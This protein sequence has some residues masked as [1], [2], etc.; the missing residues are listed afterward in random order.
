[1]RDILTIAR[2]ELRSYFTDVVILIQIFILPFIIVFG[3]CS[4]FSM[5]GITSKGKEE[6]VKAYYVRA[7]ESFEEA[8]IQLGMEK[9][10]SD[11]DASIVKYKKMVEDKTLDLLLVFPEDFKI[12]EPGSRDLSNINIY[13]NSSKSESFTLYQILSEIFDEL[14]PHTFTVNSIYE[15]D[16]YNLFD[17]DNEFR[18]MLGGVI[19]T[20]VFMAVFMICMNLASNSIAGDKEH[21]FLN[22]LLVTP[23][24]RRDLAAGKSVTILV[25]SA[26]SSISAFIGMAISLPK[27]AR[28]FELSGNSY[29]IGTYV[30]LFLCVVT[31]LFVL[32]AILLIVST[33]SKDVKQA[34]T[35]APASI[36]LIMIPSLLSSTE[37]FGRL[38]DSFGAKNYYIPVWNSV[39]LMQDI[40]S[41]DYSS[42]NL[43][44]VCIVNIITA[45]IGVWLV[46]LLFENEKVVNNG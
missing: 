22:T 34:T 46:G 20:V 42:L 28:A 30:T 19:P 36:F 3:Y 23:I 6:T 11:D 44:P 2:K 9:A 17:S 35:I 14:Q 29:G 43:I 40:I 25:V 5:F 45:V 37:G 15:E 4:L 24:K 27:I 32:A 39:K 8:F 31:A 41:V 12:A 21:G 1:M 10:P 18:K 13:Y 26:C 7:P 38:V 16:T 33:L